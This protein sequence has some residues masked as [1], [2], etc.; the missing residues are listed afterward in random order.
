MNLALREQ[1]PR[2]ALVYLAH[3]AGVAVLCPADFADAA[4]TYGTAKTP[5][6]TALHRL[7]HDSGY[8]VA[9]AHGVANV[10]RQQ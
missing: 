10:T 2:E 1:A 6:L 8:Q 9:L 3:Q 4:V 5:P 7:A